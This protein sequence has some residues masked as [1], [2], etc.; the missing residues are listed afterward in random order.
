MAGIALLGAFL[1]YL[2]KTFCDALGEKG[3]FPSGWP[4]QSPTFLLS[5]ALFVF[6]CG[7]AERILFLR[8]P[9]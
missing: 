1:F 9:P 4:L 8:K 6:C 2:M 3:S 7:I 5:Q